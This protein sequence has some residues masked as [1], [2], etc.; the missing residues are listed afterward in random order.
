MLGK[1][2]GTDQTLTHK[3]FAAG[4]TLVEAGS[5]TQ[6]AF[7]IERGDAAAWR[8]DGRR[9]T[10]LAQL[11]PGQ[12]VGALALLEQRP[13]SATVTAVSDCS[14]RVVTG[15]DLTQHLGS[16]H[17]VVHTLIDT[18]VDRLSWRASGTGVDAL[19]VA[20]AP[21]SVLH[22]DWTAGR[23]VC[24]SRPIRTM[25]DNT[26]AGWH[27]ALELRHT[28]SGTPADLDTLIVAEPDTSLL[29][30][31]RQ[32]LLAQA[33]E[34][35]AADTAGTAYASTTLRARMLTA[36]GLVDDVSAAIAEH[37]IEP[38]QLWIVVRED[39][40]PDANS[41]AW[42]SLQSRRRAG[43]QVAIADFGA[44]LAPM[45]PPL[46]GEVDAVVLAESLM[47][48][49]R[50]YTALTDDINRLARMQSLQ[51]VAPVGDCTRA[52]AAARALE[53][54]Y[55]A[56]QPGPHPP[57]AGQQEAAASSQAGEQRA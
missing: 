36:P 45:A 56:G 3:R 50:R 30:G 18:L 28:A 21:R 53:C 35:A 43:V 14:V 42:A 19:P 2:T 44:K 51:L 9:R 4:D 40:L 22:D 6:E 37:G 33:G 16:V 13:H 11:G 34:I 55:V 26:L 31:I 49:P 52:L 47:D 23:L 39:E 25:D 10:L 7:I 38:N 24:N 5:I 1:P 41:E 8:E 48:H 20:A 15:D 27:V 57:V 46:R 29:V 17:P 32:W 12:M 54:A